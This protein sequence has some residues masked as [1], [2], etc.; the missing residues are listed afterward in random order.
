MTTAVM[1]CSLAVVPN[2]LGNVELHACRTGD[3]LDGSLRISVPE[4]L[5][6]PALQPR[7]PPSSESAA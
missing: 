3:L 2:H 1:T 4:R 5:Q 6:A 7:R